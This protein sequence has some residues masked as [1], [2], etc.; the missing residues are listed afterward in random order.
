MIH[1]IAP[2]YIRRYM[3]LVRS[4]IALPWYQELT[5]NSTTWTSAHDKRSL[6]V[7]VPAVGLRATTLL[8]PLPAP[9]IVGGGVALLFLIIALCQYV[10]VRP[11][12]QLALPTIV[13]LGMIS[14]GVAQPYL[15]QPYLVLG[16]VGVVGGMLGYGLV[17]LIMRKRK[18]GAGATLLPSNAWPW[19]LESAP[20]IS[21]Q[22]WVIVC[23]GALLSTLLMTWPVAWQ[24]GDGVMT[25]PARDTKSR[26]RAE[27]LECVALC[28]YMATR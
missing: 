6:G 11:V 2:G 17:M 1:A 8:W 27:C 21:R 20:V 23:V 12:W 25:T 18:N 22:D 10:F 5:I 15:I 13:A 7:V 14:A 26:F 3:S 24:I 9:A 16:V 28:Q 19:W 4:T